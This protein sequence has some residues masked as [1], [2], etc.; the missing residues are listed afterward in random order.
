MQLLSFDYFLLVACQI[1]V[2]RA[3][4]TPEEWNGKFRMS[5]WYSDIRVCA[6]KSK[7]ENYYVQG[8]ANNLAYMRGISQCNITSCDWNGDFY[9]AGGEAASGKFSLSITGSNV[10]GTISL[11]G[12]YSLKGIAVTGTRQSTTKPSSLECFETDP[13]FIESRQPIFTGVANFDPKFGDEHIHLISGTSIQIKF[14]YYFPDGEM[15]LGQV[16]GSCHE[17]GQVCPS[18][19]YE[20]TTPSHPRDSGLELV[21][22]VNASYLLILYRFPRTVSAY[23]LSSENGGGILEFHKTPGTEVTQIINLARFNPNLP[24]F[25]PKIYS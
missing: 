25:N 8:L 21:V 16:Y 11:N 9:L 17:D 12:G 7:N 15:A 13:D 5:N 3:A 18:Q 24:Q 19:F 2:I 22:A 20:D 4:I 10:V 14:T 1:V 23:N 6:S